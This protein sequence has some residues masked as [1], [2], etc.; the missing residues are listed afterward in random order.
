MHMS[1]QR[2]DVSRRQFIANAAV[3]VAAGGGL[4][5]LTFTHPSLA[6]GLTW[7]AKGDPKVAES[8]FPLLKA[9]Y[10]TL[11]ELLENW[12]TITLKQDG[13]AV[14]RKIGTV[15]VSSPLSGIR[16]AFISVRDAEEVSDDIDVEAFTEAYLEVLTALGDAENDCYSANFADYSGGGQLKGSQ[17]IAKA[18]D[19][20]KAARDNYRDVMKILKLL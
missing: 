12:D 18:K 9:G 14:R 11:E 7:D 20:V 10:E 16:K 4:P 17:F 19:R 2:R 1:A 6:D 5:L 8:W 15:G 13:D 3:A